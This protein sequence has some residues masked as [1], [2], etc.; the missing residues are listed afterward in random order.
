MK[1]ITRRS[2][3]GILRLPYNLAYIFCKPSILKAEISGKTPRLITKCMLPFD[4]KWKD[5]R[6][7]DKVESYHSTMAFLNNSVE[8][9]M[10]RY[11]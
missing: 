1:K 4:E 5:H 2:T 6:L 3:C 8:D 7:H 11:N 10:N 9:N